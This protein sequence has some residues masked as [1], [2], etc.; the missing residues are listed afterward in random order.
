LP[1]SVPS[2][3]GHPVKRGGTHVTQISLD[4]SVPSSVGHPVKRIHESDDG[5]T[6]LAFSPL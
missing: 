3:V 6:D 4:L 5:S 2:S 1:L